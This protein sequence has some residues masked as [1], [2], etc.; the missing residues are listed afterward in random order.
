MDKLL[1]I[2]EIG[3]LRDIPSDLTFLTKENNLLKQSNSKLKF[4]KQILV[5]GIIALMIYIIWREIK[6]S[7]EHVDNWCRQRTN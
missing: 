4:E 7:D 6:D 3:L 1:E 2:G 5:C